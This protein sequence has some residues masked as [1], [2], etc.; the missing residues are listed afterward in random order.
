V[1]NEKKPLSRINLPE[2]LQEVIWDFLTTAIYL[3]GVL[4]IEHYILKGAFEN[5][6][7]SAVSY[8]TL[9][10]LEM[11]LLIKLASKLLEEFEKFSK[12]VASLR[13]VKCIIDRFKFANLY[14]ESSDFDRKVE[15]ESK[16]I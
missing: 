8:L 9:R 15:E 1:S 14:K 12:K 13:V 4:V 6:S 11:T 2:E 10:T 5:E 16:K 7:L 3:L